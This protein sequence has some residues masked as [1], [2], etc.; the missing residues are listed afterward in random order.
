MTII[1]LRMIWLISARTAFISFSVFIVST[2]SCSIYSSR[3][4]HLIHKCNMNLPFWRVT[5]NMIGCYPTIPGIRFIAVIPG[6]HPSI[7]SQSL[8]RY[9]PYLIFSTED[10]F[11]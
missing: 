2:F 10:F 9:S 4:S 6:D 8:F 1:T 3:S 7:Q 11:I 5:I